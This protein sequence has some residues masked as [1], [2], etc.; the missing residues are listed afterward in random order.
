MHVHVLYMYCILN[1][2]LCTCCRARDTANDPLTEAASSAVCHA[3]GVSLQS[4][5]Y[6]YLC[7]IDREHGWHC[8]GLY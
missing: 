6:M 5:D 7:S 3:T 1:L 4:E 8:K 2:E